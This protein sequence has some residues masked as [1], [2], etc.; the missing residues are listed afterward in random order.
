MQEQSA[1]LHAFLAP[2]NTE[3][4]LAASAAAELGALPADA[5]PTAFAAHPEWISFGPLSA[6]LDLAHVQIDNDPGR[7]RVIVELVLGHVQQ[8]D[9]QP[10][11]E[12]LHLVLT[13]SAWKE[14]ANTLYE[15]HEYDTAMHSI[16]RAIDIFQRRPA[17][18][19]D[20][21][22]ALLTYV[23]TG[24]SQAGRYSECAEGDR[25]G[26][27]RIPHTKRGTSVPAGAGDL[28]GHIL[29]DQND[30]TLAA[31]TFRTSRTV[32]ERL[33]DHYAVA[34]QNSERG[35]NCTATY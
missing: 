33:Q 22:V 34:R 21:A 27:V 1:V 26:I 29:F 10:G 24:R 28:C 31:K 6:L 8:I 30:Y 2:L 12:I 4:D 17:L 16:R 7:A 18:Q 25:R 3:A 15:F 19:L 35:N 11:N 13:G 14:H 9:A 32:A 5:W 23:C 20:H